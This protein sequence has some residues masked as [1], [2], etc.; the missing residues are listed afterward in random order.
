MGLELV[1]LDLETTGFAVDDEVTVVGFALPLGCRVFAR[2]P[3]CG[4]RV[5]DV[6]AAVREQAGTHVI[7]SLHASEAE[8]LEAVGV[9][10]AERL[11]GE[12]VLLVAFNGERWRGGFD[13]PF[14]RTRLAVLDVAWPFRELPYAD[15]LPVV[16]R[17]F[18]TTVDGEDRSDLVG[19]YSTLTDGALNALDPFDESVKAVAAWEAG[20]V[21]DVV[22]HNVA[23]I[24]RTRALGVLTERYCSKSDYD[25]KSLTPTIHD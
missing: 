10:A 21:V 19:V 1:A 4:S 24:R 17:R 12:D 6:E 11:H 16:D 18:N 7:V 13:L 2:V 5:G 14:L 22:L 8:L 20:R 3:P 23:D 15:L 25:L 9:F